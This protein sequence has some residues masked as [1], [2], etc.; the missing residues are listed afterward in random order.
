MDA[1][2]QVQLN[3]I[4]GS[5]LRIAHALEALAK[6]NVPNVKTLAETPKQRR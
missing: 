3:Q 1:N 5:L 4:N 6:E 2:T